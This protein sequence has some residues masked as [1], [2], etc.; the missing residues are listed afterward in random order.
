MLWIVI[1]VENLSAQEVRI[2][3]IIF[4][5]ANVEENQVNIISSIIWK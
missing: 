4:F 1:N 3:L 5:Q 2:T